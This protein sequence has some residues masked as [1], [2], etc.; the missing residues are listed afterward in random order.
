M[1]FLVKLLVVTDG[2]RE[3]SHVDSFLNDDV[4]ELGAVVVVVAEGLRHLANFVAC[5]CFQRAVTN[6][7]AKH[8]NRRWKVVIVALKKRK[9]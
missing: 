4:R 2:A 5:D 8:N 9:T 7:V 6:P 1:N 3:E